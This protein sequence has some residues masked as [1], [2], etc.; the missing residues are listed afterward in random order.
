MVTEKEA[1]EALDHW[2]SKQTKNPRCTPKC[3]LCY[4]RGTVRVLVKDGL[5]FKREERPCPHAVAREQRKGEAT[6]L[7]A[8]RRSK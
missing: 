7:K 2:L 1:G 6:W 5:G 8:L 3:S 4:G